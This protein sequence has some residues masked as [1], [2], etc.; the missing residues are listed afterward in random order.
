MDEVFFCKIYVFCYALHDM[1]PSKTYYNAPATFQQCMMAIFA[2]MVE[3]IIKVFKDEFLVFEYS[4]YHCLH[5]LS[6]VLKRCKE[7]NFFLN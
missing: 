3:N 7:R 5:N 4:F 6:L 1:P 2:D